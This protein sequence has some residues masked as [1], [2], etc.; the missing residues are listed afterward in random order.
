MYKRNRPKKEKLNWEKLE[1]GPR[2]CYK[3]T[4]KWIN[5]NFEWFAVIWFNE[6]VDNSLFNDS[7][8]P[9]TLKQILKYFSLS[10]GMVTLIDDF[11]V[12]W[13]YYYGHFL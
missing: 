10:V 2:G 1:H 11:S 3:Q 6:L 4:K 8:Y 5:A 9:E 13:D 12:I 7:F